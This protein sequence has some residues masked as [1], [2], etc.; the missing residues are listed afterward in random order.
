MSKKKFKSWWVLLLRGIL[1]LAFGVIVLLN[2][3]TGLDNP[4]KALID[5]S[6]YFG[7]LVFVT[8]IINIIGAL[9]QGGPRDDWMWLLTSGML[10]LLIGVLIMIYPFMTGPAVLLFM[11]FW[12]LAG[13]LLQI[14]HALLFKEHLKNWKI[15]I[16]NAVLIIILSYFYLTSDI[17]DSAVMVFY[18]VASAMLVIGVVN[19]ILSFS[20]KEMSPRKVREMR[21]NA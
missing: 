15:T 10:D 17:E 4:V 19:I 21:G 9:R 1:I 6:I 3:I 18:L 11:G 5:L 8:G 14:S 20:V 16:V 12:G 13:S 7:I 2:V